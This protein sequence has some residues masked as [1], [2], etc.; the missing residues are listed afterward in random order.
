MKIYIAG[1][2]TGYPGYKAKF[3]EAET[4]LTAQGHS[5]MNPSVLPEGFEQHEYLQICYSMIDVCEGIFML[6]NW[7]DSN[8]AKMEHEYAIANRKRIIY[9]DGTL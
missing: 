9:A 6:G 2:I 1:K 5:V 8:G 3:A 4:R 7:Q